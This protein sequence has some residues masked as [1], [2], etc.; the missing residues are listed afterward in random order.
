MLGLCGTIL[1]V[2]HAG[3]WVPAAAAELGHSGQERFGDGRMG[4]AVP[5]L[6]SLIHGLCALYPGLLPFILLPAVEGNVGRQLARTPCLWG[7]LVPQLE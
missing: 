4:K 2:R 1:F 5:P 6:G 3:C 7:L